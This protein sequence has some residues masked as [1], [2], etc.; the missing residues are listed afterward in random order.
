VAPEAYLFSHRHL[1]AAALLTHSP[2]RWRIGKPAIGFLELLWGD[3]SQEERKSDFDNNFEKLVGY[4]IGR[5]TPPV[6]KDAIIEHIDDDQLPTSL[7]RPDGEDERPV[8]LVPHWAGGETVA[9]L[10]SFIQL[11]VTVMSMSGGKLRIDTYFALATGSNLR[12]SHTPVQAICG[13]YHQCLLFHAWDKGSAS[14]RALFDNNFDTFLRTL[15][16]ETGGKE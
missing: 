5:D 3:I 7:H 11:A 2:T 12:I 1:H 4:L 8:S 6:T 9:N 14:D 15:R 10:V 16:P 13:N